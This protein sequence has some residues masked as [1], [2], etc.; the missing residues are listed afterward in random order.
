MGYAKNKLRLVHK[1]IE[2]ALKE[3][4]DLTNWQVR[5]RF[6]CSKT[7]ILRIRQKLGIPAPFSEY[8]TG[9]DL[10]RGKSFD[11]LETSYRG[12]WFGSGK[13]KRL[14]NET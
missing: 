10:K 4:P 2:K 5:E 7:C 3:N 1:A 13:R 6:G 11:V 8:V 9:Y 14:R 12:V